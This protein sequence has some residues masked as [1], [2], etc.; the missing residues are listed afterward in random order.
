MRAPRA[1]AGLALLLGSCALA[2]WGLERGRLDWQ[3][4]LAMAQPWRAFSAVAVHYSTTHLLVNL[5]AVALVAALGLA[6][7]VSWP[8][9]WA[10]LAAWP[11]T[12]FGLWLR[13]DLA[14]Y[15]GLSGVLHAGV[16][17]LAMHLLIAGTRAQRSIGALVLAGLC[18]K[19][20]SESPWGPALRA[21]PHWGISV[22]PLAHASGLVMG[23]LCAAFAYGL[24]RRRSLSRIN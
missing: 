17:V 7:R 23:V 5:G 18:L 6:A 13:P 15:G 9:V 16:A 20:L 22:A 4:A 11:L 19:V 24:A 14:H 10:W 12:Q 1:W 8:G 2:G 3:P 21:A